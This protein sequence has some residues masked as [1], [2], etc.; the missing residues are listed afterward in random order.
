MLDR[1]ISLALGHMKAFGKELE[2]MDQLFHIGLHRLARRRGLPVL[3]WTIRTP[4]DAA[5]AAALADA[6]IAEG[7]VLTADR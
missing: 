7:P 6:P 4:E 5:R 2:V 1:G 3:T